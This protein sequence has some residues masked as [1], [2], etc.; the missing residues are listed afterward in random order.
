MPV[1][2]MRHGVHHSHDRRRT[3]ATEGSGAT[4]EQL[5]APL[6]DA[7]LE[8]D[9]LLP[10]PA[11]PPPEDQPAYTE[12][13]FSAARATYVEVEVGGLNEA[14]VNEALLHIPCPN[15]HE[16]E[17]PPEM[18]GRRAKCPECG[19]EFRLRREKSIEY[20]YQQKLLDD[21]R[22]QFWLR[23]AIFTAVVVVMAIVVMIVAMVMS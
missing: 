3:P 21:K 10:D 17:T 7:D 6:P 20:Q 5:T 13:P 19:V 16:L 11:P 8:V 22:A 4:V 2:A 1:P 23:V 9:A 14:V 15:G 18:I 12:L